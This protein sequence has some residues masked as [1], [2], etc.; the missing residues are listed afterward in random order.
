MALVNRFPVTREV[1]GLGTV[2]LSMTDAV[3]AVDAAAF[4]QVVDRHRT[5]LLAH[6]YRLLGSAED[7]EDAVQETF[8]R[9][10]RSRE[11]WKGRSSIRTWLYT[12]ATNASIDARRAASR[13]P[14]PSNLS[15]LSSPAHLDAAEGEVLWLEPIADRVLYD[16]HSDPAD[17]A[18]AR[19]GLHL[20]FIAA[21]QHLSPVQRAVLV[22]RDVLGFAAAE[23][24]D[25]LELTVSSVNNHLHRA[26]RKLTEAAPNHEGVDSDDLVVRQRATDYANAFIHSDVDGLI[27][28]LH[29]DVT[30]EM[31][32]IPNWY[33]GREDVAA[34]LGV[35]VRS[36]IWRA[37]AT[38]ANTQPAVALYAP[39][40][41]GVW[42]LQ[43]LHV[44]D[45]DPESVRGIVV[46]H[47]HGSFTSFDLPATLGPGRHDQ[48]IS[49]RSQSV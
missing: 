5:E 39:D 3:V 20:A 33:R 34:F 49:D 1:S 32:P 37:L 22:L 18:A 2:Y 28:L 17:Q 42:S 38:A 44:L 46:F 23:V 35:R 15:D 40:D 47:D 7:A 43:T 19:A 31:P 10:F 11:S 25:M 24:A 8:L 4:E 26:R 48:E 30:L 45:T 12:I 16:S 27:G 21:L 29:E 6:C 41:D 14:L 36:A 13:R 9:A